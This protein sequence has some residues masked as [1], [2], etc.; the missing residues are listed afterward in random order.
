LIN[1]G[2]SEEC[3]GTYN[4]TAAV[5]FQMIVRALLS[6]VYFKRVFLELQ[7]E[8]D[9]EA[10]GVEGHVQGATQE[11]IDS[12]PLLAFSDLF[13]D[14]QNVCAICLC[15][16]DEGELLRWFPCCHDFHRGCA[17]RWLK[18]STRCPLCNWHI[19]A[20]SDNEKKSQ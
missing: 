1:S 9:D 16:Y 17:D 15:E 11:Q 3:Q 13:V 10:D 20:R 12:V 19:D 7:P 4:I 5:I 6:A 18:R 14:E 8:E 2:E